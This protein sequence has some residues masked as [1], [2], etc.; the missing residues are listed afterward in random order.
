M[1]RRLLLERGFLRLLQARPILDG[2]ILFSPAHPVPVDQLLEREHLYLPRHEQL[3]E[4]QCLCV[5]GDADP[6]S[7]PI[8]L[9]WEDMYLPGRTELLEWDRVCQREHQSVSSAEYVLEWNGVCVLSR[10]PQCLRGVCV[11]H[12]LELLRHCE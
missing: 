10:L 1:P 12:Q 9:E 3:L 6:L 11:Q 5:G 7:L 4:W 2:P 8:L